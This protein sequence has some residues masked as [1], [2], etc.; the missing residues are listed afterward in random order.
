MTTFGFWSY[1]KFFYSNKQKPENVNA[2][3]EEWLLSGNIDKPVY[4]V[5][6]ITDKEKVLQFKNIEYLYEKGGFVFYVRKSIS[7]N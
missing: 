1:A 3:N 5:S 6:K 4:I 2:L 7:V